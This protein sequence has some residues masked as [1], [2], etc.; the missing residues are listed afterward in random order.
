MNKRLIKKKVRSTRTNLYHW[1]NSF[2]TMSW[3]TQGCWASIPLF[4]WVPTQIS[5]CSKIMKKFLMSLKTCELSPPGTCKIKKQISRTVTL[6]QRQQKNL[7]RWFP[8]MTLHTDRHQLISSLL[9]VKD[10]S[11]KCIKLGALEL[12][13]VGKCNLTFTWISS[14]AI[15]KILKSQNVHHCH[16]ATRKKHVPM[17][18]DN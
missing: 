16:E 5:G 13:R 18:Q 15:S 4:H 2:L 6:T 9:A 14:K 1:I 3:V 11:M 7:Y 10:Y 12:H 8:S 17:L